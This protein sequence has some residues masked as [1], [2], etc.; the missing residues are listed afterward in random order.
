M[1]LTSNIQIRQHSSSNLIW[2]PVN[3]N[4]FADHDKVEPV[5]LYFS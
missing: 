4:C 2:D 3:T 5:S 1:K